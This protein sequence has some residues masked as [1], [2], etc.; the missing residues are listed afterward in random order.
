MGKDQLE[1]ALMK[2]A[3]VAPKEFSRAL[4]EEALVIAKVS[5][6]RTPVETGELKGSHQVQRPVVNALDIYV[7]IDVGGGSID[8]AL[9]VH[10]DLTAYHEVGQAKFLESA[11]NEAKENFAERLAKRVDLEK[12]V[13]A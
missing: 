13:S 11:I 12:L 5:S 10:E 1:K 8:Y 7:Q 2:L 4:Y 9:I 3:D 6:D